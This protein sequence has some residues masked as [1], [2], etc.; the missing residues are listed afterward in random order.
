M[1]F[2]VPTGRSGSPL[3][4]RVSIDPL[5][6]STHRV[7]GE[8]LKFQITGC[9]AGF[10]VVNGPTRSGPNQQIQAQI[11]P[12]PKNDLKLQTGPKKPES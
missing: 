11:R 4:Q 3:K 7:E 9:F 8:K 6:S 10:R 2:D 5:A 1:R 12:E